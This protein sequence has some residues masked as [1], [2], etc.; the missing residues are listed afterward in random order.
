MFS[1]LDNIN[2]KENNRISELYYQEK[3]R[4]TFET[5]SRWLNIT[6]YHILFH[7]W[8]FELLQL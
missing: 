4:A 7:I 6:I 8:F 1:K 2:R 3:S 5:P